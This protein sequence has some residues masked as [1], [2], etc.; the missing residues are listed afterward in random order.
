MASRFVPVF[1]FASALLLAACGGGDEPATA[2]VASATDLDEAAVSAGEL[3]EEAV[4]D[5]AATG[6]VTAE[7]AALAFS[8]CMRDNGFAE[9]PDPEIGA[10]GQPNLRAAIQNAD[11]DFQSGE[12][13][14]TAETCRDDVGA[15]NFGAGAR[16]G[17]A[18]AG[19]QENLLVYT[20]C[21]RDEG[22]DVGDI[23][24]GGAPGAGGQGQGGQGGAGNGNGQGGGGNGDGDGAGRAQGNGGAGFNPANRIAQFLDLDLEDPAVTAALEACEPVLE[25]AFAGFGGGGAGGRGGGAGGGGGGGGAANDTTD[26]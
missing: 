4:D 20:Q 21:L 3:A 24:F 13:Q 7:E 11:I 25:E 18:R 26:T 19:I 2:G 10:N 5:A 22:L 14:A 9:F 1:V 8:Q 6:E 17:D 16:N 15:D 23:E 12:F